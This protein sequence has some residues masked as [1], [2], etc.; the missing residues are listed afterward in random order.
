MQGGLVIVSRINIGQ[1]NVV[2]MPSRGV[3]G[4]EENQLGVSGH[5]RG[6]L[7]VVSVI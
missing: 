2:V 5:D 7:S 3:V 4:A 6:D 1:K